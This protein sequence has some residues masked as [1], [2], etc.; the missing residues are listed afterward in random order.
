MAIVVVVPGRHT[1]PIRM[2]PN[3]GLLRNIPEGAI[4]VIFE[5][6]V[7]VTSIGL[8]WYSAIGHRLPESR[9]VYEEQ[10]EPAVGVIVEH[11][12][13][14]AHSFDEVL[15]GRVRRGMDKIDA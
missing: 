8:F 5:K 13:A 1:H 11:R 10:V 15:L 12:D 9:A 4:S 7:P 14:A 6:P 3:T 2:S